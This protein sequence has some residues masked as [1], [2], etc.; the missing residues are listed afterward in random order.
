MVINAI[1][2][3]KK[4]FFLVESL[5]GQIEIWKRFPL[6]ADFGR[7][8][9]IN[10]LR[11]SVLDAQRSSFSAGKVTAVAI[12]KRAGQATTTTEQE[13]IARQKSHLLC[14]QA[15]LIQRRYVAGLLLP[16]SPLPPLAETRLV[17]TH[18][19]SSLPPA[20]QGHSH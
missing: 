8:T 10:V 18:P 19:E 9:K 13:H 4:K 15:P 16:L 11:V 5:V 3:M 2:R 12:M 17:V 7:V 14:R 6:A 20:R 1:N